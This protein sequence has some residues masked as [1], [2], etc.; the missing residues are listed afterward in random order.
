[1]IGWPSSSSTD[2]IQIEIFKMYGEYLYLVE[3]ISMV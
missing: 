1:M 3:R 2:L